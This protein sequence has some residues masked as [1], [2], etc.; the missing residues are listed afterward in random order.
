M[1]SWCPQQSA[2][3]QTDIA[4]DAATQQ[5]TALESLVAEDP[6]QLNSAAKVTVITFALKLVIHLDT[7]SSTSVGS[8]L[9]T[10]G[11]VQTA[12]VEEA[13]SAAAEADASRRLLR[14]LE[15]VHAADAA[16]DDHGRLRALARRTS[17]GDSAAAV[18]SAAAVRHRVLT[19]VSTEREAV[20]SR[21][22]SVRWRHDRGGVARHLTADSWAQLSVDERADALEALRQYSHRAQRRLSDSVTT[23]STVS[24][25]TA[26]AVRKLGVTAL[27]NVAAGEEALSFSVG[28]V[29]LHFLSTRECNV[30][31][32][33]R[34]AV[35]RHLPGRGS[36]DG[37]RV[38]HH[39]SHRRRGAYGERGGGC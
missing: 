23:A 31:R 15:A 28:S 1:L 7:S 17:A 22:L 33:S 9:N 35:L 19:S 38:R 30:S 27:K 4:T 5:V 16:S 39:R 25:S 34:V 12:A 37:F 6:D 11:A 32:V 36:K 18:A 29:S 13:Q 3:L 8:F 24:A 26:I 20:A 21:L 14:H 2:W 10:V